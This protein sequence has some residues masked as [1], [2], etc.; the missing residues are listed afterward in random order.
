MST[1][2]QTHLGESENS[3]A[4]EIHHCSPMPAWL[5][6]RSQPPMG[7]HAALGQPHA[8]GNTPPKPDETMTQIPAR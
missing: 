8:V 2:V 5:R 1:L 3:G 7:A 4:Q 6:P